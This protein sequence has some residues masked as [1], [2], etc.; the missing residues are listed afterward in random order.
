ME[1]SRGE[2]Q[3]C[4]GRIRVRGKIEFFCKKEEGGVEAGDVK[5]EVNVR[6]GGRVIWEKEIRDVTARNVEEGEGCKKEKSEK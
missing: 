5:L 4:G 2:K 6:E 1:N 3:G